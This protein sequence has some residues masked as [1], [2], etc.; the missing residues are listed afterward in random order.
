MFK[1]LIYL[2]PFAA[3]STYYLIKIS[4]YIDTEQNLAEVLEIQT[5]DII[6]IIKPYLPTFIFKFSFVYSNEIYL[7]LSS[8]GLVVFLLSTGLTIIYITLKI[9]I[10][11]VHKNVYKTIS[12]NVRDQSKGLTSTNEIEVMNNSEHE[13]EQEIQRTDRD[14]QQVETNVINTKESDMLTTI[15]KG[16]T[17][18]LVKYFNQ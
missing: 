12:R 8:L 7:M 13:L 1:L 4:S 3:L 5:S 6:D 9:S 18:P 16:T 11:N 15:K 2:A 17:P 14:S 10:L